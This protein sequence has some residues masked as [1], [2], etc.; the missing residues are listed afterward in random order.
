MKQITFILITLYSLSFAVST[1]G[2]DFSSFVSYNKEI[3]QSIDELKEILSTF[4]F[5][6]LFGNSD[7]WEFRETGIF[8]DSYLQINTFNLTSINLD[9]NK[10]KGTFNPFVE[11]TSDGNQ[12]FNLTFQFNYIGRTSYFKKKYGTGSIKVYI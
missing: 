7:N 6:S 2:S 11:V 5:Q 12:V 3:T 10:F 1:L 9:L 4:Q 8:Y